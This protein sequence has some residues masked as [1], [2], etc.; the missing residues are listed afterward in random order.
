MAV[1]VFGACFCGARPFGVPSCTP[2][3]LP[4]GPDATLS[5]FDAR[6]G[7]VVGACASD[8][9]SLQGNVCDGSSYQ[10]WLR[11]AVYEGFC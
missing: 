5:L 4:G 3:T 10:T 7:T 11:C 2:G 9:F 8:L 1:A 6:D